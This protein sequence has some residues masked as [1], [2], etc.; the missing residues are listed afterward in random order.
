MPPSRRW[1]W[2]LESASLRGDCATRRSREEPAA[3]QGVPGTRFPGRSQK[4]GA[5]AGIARRRRAVRIS[6]ASYTVACVT[7]P[8]RSGPV[9]ASSSSGRSGTAATRS[10]SAAATPASVPGLGFTPLT[11]NSRRMVAGSVPVAW[12]APPW[13]TGRLGPGGQGAAG[14][15]LCRGINACT[16]HAASF[17]HPGSQVVSHAGTGTRFPRAAGSLATRRVRSPDSASFE[18][19]CPSVAPAANRSCSDCDS[20]PGATSS[21]HGRCTRNPGWF[22]MGRVGGGRSWLS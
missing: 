5:H 18:T 1:S 12:P 13:R 7:C 3:G 20:S 19:P 11:E 16:R 6:D 2:S 17:R 9:T 15:G 4:P 8:L 10:P 22:R 21:Q 14:A